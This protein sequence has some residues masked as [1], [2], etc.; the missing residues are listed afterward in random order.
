MKKQRGGKKVAAEMA[1]AEF[2]KGLRPIH[3]KIHCHS[4]LW[5]FPV[6]LRET[7]NS[8]KTPGLLDATPESLICIIPARRLRAI[9]F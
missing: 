1:E 9:S 7:L 8:I 5:L 4:Q 3:W 2:R 6:A